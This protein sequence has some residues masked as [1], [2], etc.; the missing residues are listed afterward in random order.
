MAARAAFGT[1]F[2]P[3]PL[4]KLGSILPRVGGAEVVVSDTA[5]RSAYGISV[6][7]SW[8]APKRVLRGDALGAFPSEAFKEE[9]VVHRLLGRPSVLDFLLPIGVPSP[10]RPRAPPL[11]SALGSFD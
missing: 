5:P 10:Q 1:S 2:V 6:R 8:R 4:Q 9:V 7:P 11:P 3:K